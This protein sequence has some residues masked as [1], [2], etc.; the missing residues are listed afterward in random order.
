MCMC[1]CVYLDGKK[2]LEKNEK[3]A[4][5]TH[6]ECVKA[7]NMGTPNENTISFSTQQQISE[8]CKI[9]IETF[10]HICVISFMNV[11]GIFSRER[12][13]HF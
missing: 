1:V 4:Q 11:R 13:K 5:N 9:F 10:Q 7:K 3:R 12:Q 8:E 2:V 6:H